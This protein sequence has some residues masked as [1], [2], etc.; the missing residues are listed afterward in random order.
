MKKILLGSLLFLGISAT[1]FAESNYEY[2]EKAW[3]ETYNAIQVNPLIANYG[4]LVTS[5]GVRHDFS[6]YGNAIPFNVAK[7]IS[8]IS[9]EAYENEIGSFDGF[10]KLPNLDSLYIEGGSFSDLRPL[11]YLKKLT[12]LGFQGENNNNLSDLESLTNLEFFEYSSSFENNNKMALTDLSALS[13]LKNL[14][15]VRINTEGILPT[16]SISKKYNSYTLYNPVILSSQFTNKVNYD[17]SISNNIDDYEIEPKFNVNNEGLLKFTDIPVGT[18]YL[19]I[20]AYASD[21]EFVYDGDIRIPINWI[22]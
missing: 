2:T 19:E 17:L 13:N 21:E 14:K 4:E 18:D 9:T 15:N 20:K 16:V 6:D 3:N 5:N 11:S 12:Y 1:G 22:D 8:S 7:N 10:N